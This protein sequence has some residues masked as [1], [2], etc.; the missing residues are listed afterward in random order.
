MLRFPLPILLTAALLLGTGMSA[1]AQAPVLGSPSL[2]AQGFQPIPAVPSADAVPAAT[3]AKPKPRRVARP[4]ATR[5]TSINA[6]DRRPTLTPDTL[7][8]TAL[9]SER[10]LEIVRA[11]GW[12]SLPN[13][14]RCR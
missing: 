2:P 12:P 4:A 5:E 7:P 6:D 14:P 11:G 9:A 3:P 1:L 8:S 10:Y 13:W